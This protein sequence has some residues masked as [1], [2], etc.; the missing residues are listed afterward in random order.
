MKKN[1]LLDLGIL[2][3]FHPLQAVSCLCLMCSLT[4]L[5]LGGPS[6]MHN[7]LQEDFENFWSEC[8][9]EEDLNYARAVC[10]QVSFFSYM[11]F[12]SIGIRLSSGSHFCMQVILWLMGTFDW[13]QPPLKSIKETKFWCYLLS[14]AGFHFNQHII[15]LLNFFAYI[16]WNDPYCDLNHTSWSNLHHRNC[17]CNWFSGWCTIGSCAFDRWILEKCG[18]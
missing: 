2:S 18:M 14:H 4:F 16:R 15:G 17:K 12:S 5:I 6:L 13:L 9:W 1:R 11:S 7:F 3:Y 10:N 8:P